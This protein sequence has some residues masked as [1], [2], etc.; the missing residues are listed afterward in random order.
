MPGS[1][2]ADVGGYD[3]NSYFIYCEARTDPSTAPLAVY[4]AGGPGESSLYT[5]LD[6]ENGTSGFHDSKDEGR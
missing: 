2:L 1:S 5:A 3:M 4:F 6:G